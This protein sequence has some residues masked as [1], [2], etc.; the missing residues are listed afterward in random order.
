[1][2]STTAANSEKA[3][4][5]PGA[6]SASL[7]EA[8]IEEAFTVEAG[9]LAIGGLRSPILPNGSAPRSLPMM[10]AFSGKI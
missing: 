5:S 6:A 1:M 3:S 4:A 8:L 7:A 2:I 10:P 9:V